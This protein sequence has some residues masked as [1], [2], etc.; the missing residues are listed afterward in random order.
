MSKIPE[1]WIEV[2]LSEL[3]V[4]VT[5]KT[6]STKDKN[7]F[8]GIYPFIKP[9]DIQNQGYVT[10][11]ETTLSEIGYN[12]VPKLP[13]DSIMVTCIGNL[14]RA[15]ISSKPSATNQQINSIIP[16]N[17]INT[18]YLYNYILTMKW[19]LEKDSAATTVAIINKTKFSKLP[20]KVAPKSE[21]D[22]IESRLELLLGQVDKIKTRLDG[23]PAILK[24]F[25]QSVL[26]AAVTGK[27]TEDWRSFNRDVDSIDKTLKEVESNRSGLLKVRNKKGMDDAF[28]L[29]NLPANWAWIKAHRLAED[30]NNSICAGPFGT[31]FKAKDFRDE[32]VPIIFIRHV[33]EGGFN[34]RKPNFMDV[35]VWEE[36]HQE[37][38]V[39]GG[40]LL[41]T[42]LG[43]PPGE[44][45][46]YPK[47]QGTA[48]VTPDVL[49]MNVDSKVC[50]TKYLMYFFNSMISKKII[51]EL[52][53]G[54][55]RLR[56]DIAMFKNFPIPTPPLVEQEEILKRVESY[57]EL[58][59]SIESKINE[60]QSRVDN[61]TQSILAKAFCGD[62]TKE[63]REL[64][65][66]LITGDNSAY[67]LLEKIKIEKDKLKIKKK[68]QKSKGTKVKT[69]NEIISVVEALNRANQPL[70]SQELLKASGFPN[71]S[72]T[73]LIERFFL[74]IRESLTSGKIKKS[75]KD[76]NDIFE[77]V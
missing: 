65:R 26:S 24:S 54:A 7:N 31:I 67:A 42:K 58:A 60:A 19:W 45:C 47:D 34:Q 32:G 52:A 14:G 55:T 33:K 44:S 40:E 4:I 8:D 66:D 28:Q 11:S 27:L 59:D 30:S 2:E 10:N 6:P 29:D 43:D 17:K 56:I 57:L 5:G 35:K 64:N 69:K 72:S 25:R 1:E 62:L 63:W 46:I 74:D 38:S 18:K 61:L 20:V 22:E 37:Y 41:I 9:G 12:K 21:Q 3:G 76:N 15:A 49:K 71:D 51:R 68:T 75:R 73:D 13:K 23:I 70:S 77:L 16:H 53:F 48:M 36:F 39:H 50:Y